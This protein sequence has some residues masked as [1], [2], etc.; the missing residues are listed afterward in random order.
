MNQPVPPSDLSFE[1]LHGAAIAA[2]VPALAELRSQVFRDWPYLYEGSTAYEI[3]YLQMYLSSPRSLAV[4]VH[5]GERIVGAT[6]MLPLVDA[7]ADLQQP[8]LTAGF[9]RERVAYF[10][11]SVLLREYRGRGLG[12]AFFSERERHARALGLPLCAFCAV[13]RAVDDPRKPVDY[14]GN[15]LFW[16]HR[17]YQRQPQ[18]QSSLSWPDIGEAVSSAKPM[19]FWLREMPAA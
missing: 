5:D 11:E 3:E 7:P 19:T 9:D 14:V 8:F 6:T 2:R 10:G 12:V 15:D 18:M 4:L 13:D 1:R 17:G 16:T